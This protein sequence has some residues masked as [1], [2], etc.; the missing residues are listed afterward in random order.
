MK[1]Y[2]FSFKNFVED[3]GDGDDEEFLTLRTKTTAEKV[4]SFVTLGL[5]AGVWSDEVLYYHSC[6]VSYQISPPNPGTLPYKSS[7]ISRACNL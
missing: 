5:D 7:I 3:E 2:R 6:S 4:G 1:F